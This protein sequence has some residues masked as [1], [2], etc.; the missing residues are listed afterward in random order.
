[1]DLGVDESRFA[2]IGPAVHAMRPARVCFE[3]N[4]HCAKMTLFVIPILCPDRDGEDVHRRASVA[5][6][7]RKTKGGGGGGGGVFCC[8]A[9]T[10]NNDRSYKA[11]VL[12][13]SL[14]YARLA[15]NTTGASRA[16]ECYIYYCLSA[17]LR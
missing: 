4:A 13:R 16:H 17:R 2:S 12:R 6:E 8:C 10:K 9:G 14:S 7:V 1:M 3:E 5:S 15:A 11:A